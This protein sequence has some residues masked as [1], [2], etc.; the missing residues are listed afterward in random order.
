MCQCF[1]GEVQV[2]TVKARY[3]LEKETKSDCCENSSKKD[4]TDCCDEG[5]KNCDDKQQDYVFDLKLNFKSNFETDFSFD[6]SPNTRKELY[7]LIDIDK[8]SIKKEKTL[9]IA[10]VIKSPIKKVIAFIIA[11]SSKAKPQN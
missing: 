4:N 8:Q 7:T 6:L 10:T 3:S 11:K 1:D 5:N 2:Y 9:D